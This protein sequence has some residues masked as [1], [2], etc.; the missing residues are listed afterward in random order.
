MHEGGVF[1]IWTSHTCITLYTYVILAQGKSACTSI[2]FEDHIFWLDSHSRTRSPRSIGQRRE[3]C[4]GSLRDAVGRSESHHRHFFSEGFMV[5][6]PSCCQ[7]DIRSGYPSWTYHRILQN[8]PKTRLTSPA[9]AVQ[10]GRSP[11][12][13]GDCGITELICCESSLC[14]WL[15][16]DFVAKRGCQMCRCFILGKLLF[17]KDSHRLRKLQLFYWESQYYETAEIEVTLGTH[18]DRCKVGSFMASAIIHNSIVI[19]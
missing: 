11:A 13:G 10:Y 16:G 7:G 3:P 5:L 1:R 15:L 4:A 12:R 9:K 18:Y 19:K 2:V 14:V 17:W 6:L 8:L